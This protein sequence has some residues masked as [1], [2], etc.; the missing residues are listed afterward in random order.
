MAFDVVTVENIVELV[1]DMGYDEYGIGFCT[2][3]YTIPQVP[4]L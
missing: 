2:I 3:C 4:R 1:L